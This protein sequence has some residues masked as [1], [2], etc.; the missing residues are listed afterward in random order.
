MDG[1][2]KN[3]Y[4]CVCLD[5]LDPNERKNIDVYIMHASRWQPLFGFYRIKVKTF[6]ICPLNPVISVDCFWKHDKN[7][8]SHKKCE[9]HCWNCFIDVM[10]CLFSWFRLKSWAVS[11]THTHDSYENNNSILIAKTGKTNS[12]VY[13]WV[14]LV[15]FTL[16]FER[17]C[18]FLCRVRMIFEW[19]VTE[20]KRTQS[21]MNVLRYAIKDDKRLPIANKRS[22][23]EF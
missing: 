7:A 6:K 9:R 3:D 16:T 19:K 5:V 23:C 4:Y 11:S 18:I 10:I 13:F 15:I 17:R 22:H 1:K 8:S 12:I 20:H 2:L 14:F 21:S